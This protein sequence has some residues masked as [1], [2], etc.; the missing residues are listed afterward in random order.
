MH[1]LLKKIKERIPLYEISRKIKQPY[2][3]AYD[4]RF[5]KQIR[6]CNIVASIVYT[7]IVAFEIMNKI[8]DLYLIFDIIFVV[9]GFFVLIG[10]GYA[11]YSQKIWYNYWLCVIFILRINLGLIQYTFVGS[12]RFSDSQYALIWGYN[13]YTACDA[14]L[15]LIN[16]VSHQNK[17]LAPVLC[18][19]FSVFSLFYF[20]FFFLGRP[21]GI[22][23]WFLVLIY[24]A[25]VISSVIYKL[26]LQKFI[27]EQILLSL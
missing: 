5:Y 18:H 11:H 16:N 26:I 9:V 1:N 21:N 17:M 6:F 15:Y 10:V 13:S 14:L 19:L 2:L 4:K 23:E 20:L 7:L 25:C 22:L 12:A 24:G 27:Q 8:S 3:D